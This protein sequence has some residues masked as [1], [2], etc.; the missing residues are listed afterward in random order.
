MAQVRWPDEEEA[1]GWHEFPVGVLIVVEEGGRAYPALVLAQHTYGTL[2]A[3][4]K[5]MRFVPYHQAPPATDEF[6]LGGVTVAHVTPAWAIGVITA[7]LIAATIVFRFVSSV[8][9]A[10]RTVQTPQPN[11]DALP[12]LV[13]VFIGLL[14]LTLLLLLFK[15]AWGRELHVAV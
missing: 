9:H 3:P 4:M 7:L 15:A 8:S 6:L 11:I 1:I 12:I 14:L 13:L 10:F 2:I 5:H